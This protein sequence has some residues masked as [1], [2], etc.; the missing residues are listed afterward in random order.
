MT[1]TE[2]LKAVPSIAFALISSVGA[3]LAGHTSAMHQ[4]A[5]QEEIDRMMLDKNGRIDKIKYC[6]EAFKDYKRM[7]DDPLGLQ[8]ELNRAPFYFFFRKFYTPP[9]N[10]RNPNLLLEVNDMKF[11][12]KRCGDWNVLDILRFTAVFYAI[13]FAVYAVTFWWMDKGSSVCN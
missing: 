11:W 3:Y 12:T 2:V 13:F 10:R 4:H 9:L 6:K 5:S 1:K 8:K 7:M